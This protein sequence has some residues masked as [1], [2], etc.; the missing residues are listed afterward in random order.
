MN[1]EIKQQ[2][3]K[4]DITPDE[5]GQDAGRLPGQVPELDAK[6]AAT[7]AASA[8][9]SDKQLVTAN[10]WPIPEGTPDLMARAFRTIPHAKVTEY[11]K[12][13]DIFVNKDMPFIQFCCEVAYLTN[14]IIAQQDLGGIM[15]QRQEGPIRKAAIDRHLARRQ[16]N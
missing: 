10:S 11:K 4:L 9:G 8:A 1:E 14:P 3:A 16:M 2:A 6:D 13:W 7:A 5:L 15:A 12:L